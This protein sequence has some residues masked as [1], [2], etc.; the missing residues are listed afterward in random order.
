[1]KT[2]EDIALRRACCI[3][4]L[5]VNVDSQSSPGSAPQKF[6]SLPT[7]A[8][9]EVCKVHIKV[10]ACC[11]D[12]VSFRSRDAAVDGDDLSWVGHGCKGDQR[13]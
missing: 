12:E 10:S 5:Q 2:S 9:T 1:M 4:P 3:F 13:R 8:L 7:T 6:Q 11:I